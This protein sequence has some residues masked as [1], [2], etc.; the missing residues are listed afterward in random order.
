MTLTALD[1]TQYNLVRI[2]RIAGGN[3]SC[4]LL[5]DK[6]P[7]ENIDPAIEAFRQKLENQLSS[8]N[9]YF[10]GLSHSLE[11]YPNG[12]LGNAL[13]QHYMQYGHSFPGSKESEFPS[14]Y[15]FLHDAHHVLLGVG[16]DYQGEMDVVAFEGALC[17]RT[18][19]ALMPILT[20]LWGFSEC[21]QFTPDFVSICR[22]WQIG[23]GV[24]GDLLEQWD[25]EKDLPIQV[26]DLQKQY[27]ILI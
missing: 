20:Q 26:N 23:S 2:A 16:T 1:W 4:A 22:A 3:S 19:E 13:Y 15:I 9:D 7:K 8:D 24:K 17:G 18:A 5:L 6:L 12:S 25:I 27:S 21:K 10:Y 11:S 14:R